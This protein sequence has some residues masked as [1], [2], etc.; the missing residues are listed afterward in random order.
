M[1]RAYTA[2]RYGEEMSGDMVIAHL[3]RETGWTLEYTRSLDLM[4]MMKLLAIWSGF[5][6][7]RE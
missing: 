6:K 7:A 5:D 3:V 1:K 2:A 4:D